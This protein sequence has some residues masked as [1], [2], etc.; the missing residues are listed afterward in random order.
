MFLGR[1]DPVLSSKEK[2]VTIPTQAS[3]WRAL[4]YDKYTLNA[5]Q[6]KFERF[7]FVGYIGICSPSRASA[8]FYSTHRCSLVSLQSAPLKRDG[9][10]VPFLFS[11][12]SW[13]FT[14]KQNQIIH[15]FL[16][17]F[18]KVRES[19]N[20]QQGVVKPPEKSYKLEKATYIIL[21][22]HKIALGSLKS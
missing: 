14:S 20:F 22:G 10:A 3:F 16:A 19:S 12:V 17:V 15:Y 9:R 7:S 13:V 4:Q 6:F 5:N 18:F 1:L 8:S 2:S 11:G 21:G